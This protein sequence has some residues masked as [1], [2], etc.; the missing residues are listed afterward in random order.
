M[1]DITSV[2]FPWLLHTSDPHAFHCYV[3]FG[4]VT[5]TPQSVYL[6]CCGEMLEVFPGCAITNHAVL[7][8]IALIFQCTVYAFLLQVF[9]GHK[10]CT[11]LVLVDNGEQ[12][13]KQSCRMTLPPTFDES[14]R[15]STA[16]LTLEA[17][18]FIL[19]ILTHR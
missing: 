1:L 16:L 12:F 4:R 6:V 8:R 9:L 19:A 14:S 3:V 2:R 13:S 17:V 10:R 7:N 5:M 18:L 15:R 11:T